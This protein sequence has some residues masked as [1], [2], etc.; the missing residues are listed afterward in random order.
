MIKWSSRAKVAIRKL[1]EPLQP[2]DVYVED[3]GD[4][5]F[6]RRLLNYSVGASVQIA[7]VFSLGGRKAVITK[8]ENYEHSSRPA[9]F[10]IDGDLG[11]VRGAPKPS[12]KGVHQH[13]AYCIENLLVCEKALIDLLLEETGTTEEEAKAKLS[14][15][16]WL[17]TIRQPLAELFA[18]YATLNDLYP[19]EKTVAYGVGK[20]STPRRTNQY[21]KLD[22][23]K[24]NE[25]RQEML[26]KAKEVCACDVVEEKYANI[27]QRVITLPEPLYAVS[28]KDYVLPLLDFHLQ[29][30]NC[31]INRAN[32]R[33]RLA[34]SGDV[35]RFARLGAALTSAA[36]GIHVN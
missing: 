12:I 18:A 28:G 21:S 9:L 29:E 2:I 26:V 4:E 24:T 25:V 22:V 19:A 17:E 10:V 5:T 33:M 27:L 13:D 30:L 31:R 36:K 14:F 34:N 6:Y 11:W 3:E 15:S 16:L 20:L 23:A 7:R 1:F 32:L 8:A 35:Q